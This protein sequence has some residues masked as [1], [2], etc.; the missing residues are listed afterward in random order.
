MKIGL[1][2]LGH[3]FVVS[4]HSLQKLNYFFCICALLFSCNSYAQTPQPQAPLGTNQSA[5]PLFSAASASLVSTVK[6]SIAVSESPRG[7]SGSQY[8]NFWVKADISAGDL[9]ESNP[10]RVRWDSG[11]EHRIRSG[12]YDAPPSQITSGS[13]S[14]LDL[15]KTYYWHIVGSN[16]TKSAEASFTV[17]NVPSQPELTVTPNVNRNLFA[18][19]WTAVANA[20]RYELTRN[21]AAVNTA[22]ASL[23]GSIYKLEVSVLTQGV[24]ETFNI[25]ACNSFGCSSGQNKIGNYPV[26]PTTAAIQSPAVGALANNIPTFVASASSLQANA[27]YTIAISEAPRTGLNNQFV[28]F[29]VS[30]ALTNGQVVWG[31]SWQQRTRNGNPDGDAQPVSGAAPLTL[32][33]GK[34]YY[35]HIV[36]ATSNGGISKSAQGQFTV[37][38]V[39]AQPD[40][41]VTPNFNRYLF[42]VTWNAVANATRYELSR[43]GNLMSLAGA[44]FSGS[45]Y[46]LE[47]D[48]SSTG[49]DEVFTIKACNSLGCSE[50][51]NKIGNYP[52]PPT[53]AIIQ[54]PAVGAQTIDTPTFSAVASSLQV[55]ATYTIA[56]SEAPRTGLN[57]QFV[58]FW[59]SP[60]LTNGQVV[61]GSNWQQRT[62]NGNPDGDAQ[63]VSNTSLPTLTSGKTYYWHVVGV[64]TNG[65]VSKSVQGQFTVPTITNKTYFSNGIGSTTPCFS[66]SAPDSYQSS[67]EIFTNKNGVKTLFAKKIAISKSAALEHVCLDK[68]WDFGAGAKQ[69]LPLNTAISWQIKTYQNSESNSVATY[70][71]SDFITRPNIVVVYADDLGWDDVNTNVGNGVDTATGAIASFSRQTNAVTF[72][73]AYA[74]AAICAPS[75]ASLMT[76]KYPAKHKVYSVN[77]WAESQTN[78]HSVHT[79]PTG[80]D[81]ILPQHLKSL[82]YATALIGKWHLFENPENLD[83]PGWTAV[84]KGFNIN[85]AGNQAGKPDDYSRKTDS[86]FVGRAD[87][88]QVYESNP[89]VM[90]TSYLTYVDGEEKEKVCNTLDTPALNSENKECPAESSDENDLSIILS[91]TANN[92]LKHQKNY[93]YFDPKKLTQPFFLY[94][95]LYDPHVPNPVKCNIDGTGFS[96]KNYECMVGRVDL[97]LANI[98]AGL[99]GVN[100]DL[101]RTGS[102]YIVFTS[103]NGTHS[104]FVVSSSS[105]S[106]SSARLKGYKLQAYEGGI[107]VPLVIAGPG[108]TFNS[109]NHTP[110]VT[111]DLYSTLLG[112][113]GVQVLDSSLASRD[114]RALLLS[115]PNLSPVTIP[116]APTPMREI[117]W[118]NPIVHHTDQTALSG[119][120]M[121]VRKGNYKL[122]SHFYPH[123]ESPGKQYLLAELYN[124]SND[125]KENCNLLTNFTGTTRCGENWVD[126]ELHYNELRSLLK[127]HVCASNDSPSNYKLPPAISYTLHKYKFL[128]D[129]FELKLINGVEISA[130]DAA[131]NLAQP[132]FS[133]E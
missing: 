28:N 37:G 82:G 117:Y 14:S 119:A 113:A 115:D 62:R 23:S 41:A 105:S 57:N 81:K 107:R 25:K 55:G 86:S 89:I 112:M 133:C 124:L 50:G 109:V 9:L 26:P 73:N 53:T 19:S 91:T 65:G 48:V 72:S 47:I 46:K 7:G 8:V 88:V 5:T 123:T 15:G 68:S 38:T 129:F 34:T 22:S 116:V 35:W 94:N 69:P 101:D 58:N 84:E 13:P 29:W 10:N 104:G 126:I 110:V 54:S 40:L 118:F 111:S 83:A 93:A 121:A 44:S 2:P 52:F 66:W 60:A 100:N 30:P 96:H 12:G 130:V 4:P 131:A 33:I 39:P 49:V 85:W 92:Y 114:L 36:G 127:T 95:A 120:S 90:K 32:T 71:G 1:I 27:T 59:V 51:Q 128:P 78:L 64:G 76:G 61:W 31:S 6:Y 102:T 45:T 77:K 75:R 80:N 43:D 122:I 3:L 87:G 18:V 97:A 74:N 42:V 106:S 16:G 108:I 17:G 56:I 79:A 63:I 67:I 132:R 98:L 70:V 20:T 21:N 103:D 125:A 24:N 99:K 11:W